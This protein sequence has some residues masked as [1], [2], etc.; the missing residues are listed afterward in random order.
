M[1]GLL[2]KMPFHSR[3][4]LYSDASILIIVHVASVSAATIMPSGL[5]FT[6]KS[7]AKMAAGVRETASLSDKTFPVFLNIS[8]LGIAMKK[9]LEE[10]KA[11]ALRGNVVDMAVGIIIGAAFGKIVSSLVGDILMPLL[12]LLIGGIHFNDLKFVIKAAVMDNGK[13]ISPEVALNYGNFIQMTIDFII[14]AF[15]IFMIVKAVSRLSF[16]K[17][18]DSPDAPPPPPDIQLLTEIRDLLKEE[19]KD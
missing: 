3:N 4:V 11:F 9:T 13:V 19:K 10:F 5:H 14:I 16:K 8:F 2:E 17:V 1:D 18:E 15:A 12:G 6:L 7:G